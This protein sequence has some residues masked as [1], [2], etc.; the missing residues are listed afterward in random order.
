MARTVIIGQVN[1]EMSESEGAT[2]RRPAEKQTTLICP[3]AGKVR[4]PVSGRKQQVYNCTVFAN[5]YKL[6]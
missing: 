5:F 6:T 4:R 2:G 3:I 1:M